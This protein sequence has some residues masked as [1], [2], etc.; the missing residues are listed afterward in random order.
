MDNLFKIIYFSG[1][2]IGSVIRI[3]YTRVYK[4]KSA[5]DDRKTVTDAILISLPGIGMFVLPIIFTVTNWLDFADY[6]LPAETGWIGV[7]LFLVMLWLLWRSHYDLGL[8]W[9][10]TMEIMDNHALITGGVYQYIRH[11]MYAA[12][13]VW[14]IAQPLLLHNWIAGFSMIITLIPGLLYRIPREEQMMFEHFGER[15]RSYSETT[16][17]IFPYL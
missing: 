12:H 2:L 4:R 7:V 13:L 10:P 5:K 16:Y 1:V 14:G 6:L 17:R 8:N 15:Y 3:I 11:P 9:T